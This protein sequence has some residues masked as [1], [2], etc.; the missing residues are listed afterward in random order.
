MADWRSPAE[1]AAATDLCDD[2][3]VPR[4]RH[5]KR[6]VEHKSSVTALAVH[7]R[8]PHQA[9]VLDTSCCNDKSETSASDNSRDSIDN[10][11]RCNGAV[12]IGECNVDYFNKHD[13]NNDDM[14]NIYL[15]NGKPV[16]VKGN[17]K[18]TTTNVSGNEKLLTNGNGNVNGTG[19][20]CDRKLM[21]DKRCMTKMLE[22]RAEGVVVVV[23]YTSRSD[24]DGEG[25]V[26]C[27]IGDKD[28]NATVVVDAAA[29]A[30]AVSAIPETMKEIK[31]QHKQRADGTVEVV[32]RL[33]C[34]YKGQIRAAEDTLVGPCGK[35]RCADRYD[36][37]ESSDR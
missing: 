35:K 8:Q 1:E 18:I 30:V 10:V 27:K 4:E 7:H 24:G 32:A 3:R 25:D 16:S 14:V 22:K 33:G 34:S 29:A 6:V 23:D 20:C 37:S 12:M 28:A 19:D 9:F 11:A 17:N 13:N 26:K 36:S 21:V 5:K 31:Q 15:L 2:S